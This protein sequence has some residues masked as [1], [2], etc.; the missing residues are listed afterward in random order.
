MS[1]HCK[2]R[3][4]I[5]WDSFVKCWLA[6]LISSLDPCSCIGTGTCLAL[7]CDFNSSLSL[8][9]SKNFP[10]LVPFENRCFDEKK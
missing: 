9:S 3:D 5:H 1:L 2:F 4:P 6:N 7:Y 8:G 10:V